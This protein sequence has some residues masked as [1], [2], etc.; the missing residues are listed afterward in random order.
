MN[1]EINLMSI[2]NVS[3]RELQHSNLL[4][5]LLAPNETHGLDDFFIKEF[6]KLY[7]KENDYQD[8]GTETSKLSVFDFVNMKFDDLEIK[9]EHKNIDILLLSPA[10]KLCILI[11][12]KI[13]SKESR[14]QLTKYRLYIENEYPEYR[15]KIYIYLSLFEQKISQ[16]EEHHYIRLTYDHIKKLIKLALDRNSYG[17]SNNTRFVLEQYLQTLK[18]LMNENEQ[19]EK[20][21]KDLYKKYKA[22]FDLV[23]KYATPNAASLVPHRLVELI[24][25]EQSII[26]F[27]TSKTYVR[28]QPNFIHRLLPKL[29]EKGY[30]S[31]D[32]DL[33]NNWLLLFEFNITTNYIYFDHKI[34]NYSD[35]ECR[36]KLY[37]LYKAN[38]TIF[39]PVVKANGKLRKSW[40]QA[41]QKK[42]LTRQE[43]TK[44]INEEFNDLDGLIE[45]RFR[46]LID[47]DL[48][49]I[50]AVFEKALGD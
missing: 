35:Q 24:K 29:K 39:K 50:E 13:Y 19:I 40:H 2:L 6:I 7:F 48:K 8:L 21:S 45:K 18:S 20:L 42:I 14:G 23:F 47:Q 30:V 10:N 36:K 12:N 17:K 27:S 9:R 34:G 33:S 4:A 31:L 44:F 28:F 26:P 46:E 16:D 25:K 15:H 5:W 32:D 41:F 43:Y 11:E 3:H 22:A 38:Q 37:E 1:E 49:K